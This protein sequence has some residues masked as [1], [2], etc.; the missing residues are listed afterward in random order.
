VRYRADGQ[1]ELAHS[2]SF[3]Q[4]ARRSRTQS[5]DSIPMIENN[6]NFI[7][8]NASFPHIGEKIRLFW[9]NPEFVALMD[10][11]QQNNRGA[12]RRG[13]PIDIA[14]ALNVLDSEHGLA[15]PELARK[16]DMWGL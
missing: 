10:E 13:F 3:E 9:G 4:T 11:L 1:Q 6:E 7:L 12:L 16:S 15:F 2:A 5:A 14:R 8:I